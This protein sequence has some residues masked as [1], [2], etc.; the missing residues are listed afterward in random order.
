MQAKRIIDAI[1]IPAIHS[2]MS[3][4]EMVE[5][6]PHTKNPKHYGAKS[7]IYDPSPKS[8]CSCGTFVKM[9]SPPKKIKQRGESYLSPCA[10]YVK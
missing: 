1:Y 3:L 4:I 8:G 5:C 7:R 9:P 2:K 10:P 6:Y